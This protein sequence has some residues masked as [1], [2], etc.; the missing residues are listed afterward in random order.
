MTDIIWVEEET[1]LGYPLQ[2]DLS[3]LWINEATNNNLPSKYTHE[4]VKACTEQR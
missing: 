3:S 4:D 1:I 2:S